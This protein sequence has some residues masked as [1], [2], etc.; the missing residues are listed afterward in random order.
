MMGLRIPDDDLLFFRERASV[1]GLSLNGWM[2]R[3]LRMAAQYDAALEDE[4]AEVK[5]R[6]GDVDRHGDISKEE[7]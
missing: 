2:V 4:L 5:R 7:R 6:S 1:L 3:S